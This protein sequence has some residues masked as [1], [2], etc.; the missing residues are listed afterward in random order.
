VRIAWLAHRDSLNPRAGG[1]EESVSEIAR[2]LVAR[3]HEVALVT[4]SFVGSRSHETVNGVRVYRLGSNLAMHLAAPAIVRET[5]RPD[6]V[7]EDLAHVAPWLSRWYG[8]VPV[9]AFF[10]HFHARTL[11]G[12]VSMVPRMVLVGVE[13]SYPWVFRG[14]TF[15][16]TS[17]SAQ[18]DLES[19]GVD[20]GKIAL[21]E[22]GVDTDLFRPLRQ[23]TIPRLIHFSGLRDYKRPSHA[24]YCLR[25]LRDAGVDAT[26]SVVGDGPARPGLERLSTEL[27]L[28]RWIEFP[29]RLP[30][31][32]LADLVAS[33]WV[34]IQCST[35]EGWGLTVTEAAACGVPTAGYK[36]PGVSDSVLTGGRGLL[37][38]EG[39]V[40]SL[41]V[42]AGQLIAGRDH[43]RRECLSSSRSRPWSAVA[44]DWERVLET[45][46]RGAR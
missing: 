18:A 2:H 16:V 45:E 22:L 6:L 20:R 26:L 15:V 13:R 25:H 23:S 9:V 28:D 43:W 10:R 12:Q 39:D 5:I 33:C 40:K 8:S 32:A 36:V 37:V 17:S 41:A 7:I 30:R 4:T 21:I 31:P 27:G 35:S 19:L 3:G 42:A 34:N 11:P 14:C 24:I 29:G 44:V 1:A 38:A 46:L